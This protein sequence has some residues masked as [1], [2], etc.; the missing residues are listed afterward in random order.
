MIKIRKTCCI[1]GSDKITEIGQINNLPVS[2]TIVEEDFDNSN[3]IRHNLIYDNC[4][5]CNNV[6][7]REIIDEDKLYFNNHNT[8]VVGESWKNHYIEFSKFILKH[9]NGKDFF[10][11]GDP[12]AKIFNILENNVESWT[13]IE[14]TPNIKTNSKKLKII[15]NFFN[16]ETCKDLK[17]SSV[18]N[19]I[20][21]HVFEHIY[22]PKEFL[23]DIH[24]I[25][26]DG[27][28]LLI[29]I[30]NMLHIY[31]NN[32]VPILGLNFEHTFYID[33][34]TIKNL[35]NLTG[36]IIDEV[37]EY[38]NHSY[39]ISLK[40]DKI[41]NKK[42][43]KNKKRFKE[44]YNKIIKKL[45]DEI[46]DYNNYEKFYLYGAHY[47]SQLLCTLGLDNEKIIY[48]L[49]NSID[50]INK[51]IY[52]FDHIVKSP[53]I[54]SE[55]SNPNIILKIDVYKKEIIKNLININKDCIIN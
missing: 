42:I 50:K 24:S 32:L 51:K 43:R 7:I 36:F 18:K 30:P 44:K 12:S 25:L 26:Q 28:K 23:D 4:E 20:M 1:C 29:S 31:K 45:S 34:T 27:G 2:P 54:V 16:T 47:N 33:I 39:F 15:N 41:K 6:Q 3:I 10:E 37:F 48:I 13:I 52:G 8:C 53:Q 35:S 40:K 5:N 55:K 21:S 19:V 46:N 38:Q 14:P 9:S 17:N 49:D 11:I 22:N